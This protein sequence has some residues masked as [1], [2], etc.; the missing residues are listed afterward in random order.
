MNFIKSWKLYGFLF[1]PYRR[2]GMGREK[3]DNMD[4]IWKTPHTCIVII[5]KIKLHMMQIL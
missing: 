5:H 1:P 4:I 3:N 2:A